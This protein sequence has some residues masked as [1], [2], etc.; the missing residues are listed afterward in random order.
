MIIDIMKIDE[1]TLRQSEESTAQQ[2]RPM[3][4]PMKVCSQKPDKDENGGGHK[5]AG[6]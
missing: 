4:N 2:S 3:V 5:L 6:A 1:S